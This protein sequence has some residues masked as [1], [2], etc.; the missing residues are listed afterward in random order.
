V[1]KDKVLFGQMGVVAA[2][3]MGGRIWA[4]KFFFCVLDEVICE[5]KEKNRE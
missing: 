5:E 2:I 3:V 1:E 4:K